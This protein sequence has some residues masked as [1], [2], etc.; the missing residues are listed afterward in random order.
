M[1]RISFDAIDQCRTKQ[2]APFSKRDWLDWLDG[3][4]VEWA[5]LKRP[6][7]IWP[8]HAA[9]EL[10]SK[11]DRRQGQLRRRHGM[12][13]SMMKAFERTGDPVWMLVAAGIASQSLMS[14]SFE[15]SSE[16]E[17]AASCKPRA[18]TKSRVS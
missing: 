13:A 11:W 15:F 4:F 9:Y 16:P 1:P 17:V 2:D 10:S 3:L 18:L 12:G 7:A 6:P 8:H 14:A 5:E